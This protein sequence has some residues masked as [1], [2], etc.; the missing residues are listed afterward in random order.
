MEIACPR[1]GT[2][3]TS[4]ESIS[5][6]QVACAN[7]SCGI[8][9]SA[10]PT[11]VESLEEPALPIPEVLGTSRAI[12]S[13]LWLAAA[14]ASLAPWGQPRRLI[15]LGAITFATAAAVV[16]LGLLVAAPPTARPGVP[17]WAERLVPSNAKVVGV[18]DCDKLV[19]SEFWQSIGKQLVKRGAWS[20]LGLR[21]SP[22]E[23]AEMVIYAVDYRRPVFLFRTY[24]GLRLEQAAKVAGD[25]QPVMYNDVT[26]LSTGTLWVARL[27]PRRFCVAF[28]AQDIEAEIDLCERREGIVLRDEL[29]QLFDSIPRA[30]HYLAAALLP[31]PMASS[32]KGMG[33]SLSLDADAQI[34]LLILCRN[35]TDARNRRLEVQSALRDA[36]KQWAI[37]PQA[38]QKSVTDL[39]RTIEASSEERTLQISAKWSVEDLKLLIDRVQEAPN[40]AE[41]WRSVV[42]AI[43]A[44]ERK[45]QSEKPEAN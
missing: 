31:A 3:C 16:M 22:S 42:G 6:R 32:V 33:L 1:C 17:H 4:S 36:G 44:T 41:V 20:D 11:V 45:A 28:S 38:V 14:K 43:P 21:L 26:Y 7:P 25:S 40:L 39:A 15:R 9:F 18:V 34:E 12:G 8:L 5:S 37:L 29:A 23:I 13:A 35:E 19:R 24:K 10:G 27:A 30:D 2:C